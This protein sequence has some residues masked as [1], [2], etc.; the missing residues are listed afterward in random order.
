MTFAA[1][2][3]L[4]SRA[5]ATFALVALAL[6]ALACASQPR[7]ATPAAVELGQAEPPTLLL[8]G[9]DGFRWDFLSRGATPTLSRLAAEGVHAQRLIPSFPTKTFPNHYT[10]VTGLRPAEHGLVANNVFD[11]KTGE[12]FGLS[13]RAAVADGKWY[14][15]EPIW[16]TAE[17]AGLRTAPLFWPGSEAEILGVRPSYA[18]P[19]DSGWSPEERV[20]RVLAWLDLP[21]AERPRFLTLYFETVDSSA[22]RHGPA[23]SEDLTRALGIVDG[24]VKRLLDGL[25]RRGSRSN[26]DLLI[27][28][29]HGM[30]ATSADRL[31]FLD[32]YVEPALANVIDWTPVLGLWP[33]DEHR[34]SVYEALAGAHP[35]LAVYRRSEIPERFEFSG[36]ERIPPIVGIS[37]EGWNVTSRARHER[38]PTC[39]DGGNHGYDQRL[40]S[41]GALLIGHGP[42]FRSA[43]AL[44]PV[45]N[46]HLYNVMC[47]ILGL[48][49]APNSGDPDRVADFLVAR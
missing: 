30:A 25:E 14:G 20:D 46:Y 43:A 31:I 45:E 28:S 29:D 39:S 37:D 4:R 6:L 48:E 44:E 41:M 26:I 12:R 27:V 23:P 21:H 33:R 22:H 49:P 5:Y 19:F 34:D 3:R 7:R 24:A 40:E 17:R 9:L 42:S 32:D 36:H 13:N 16:V 15:G 10:I 8:I 11:P 38:C 1:P 47:S 35:N 18:L 2:G